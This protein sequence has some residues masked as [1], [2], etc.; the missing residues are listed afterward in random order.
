MRLGFQ[1]RVWHDR[2]AGCY[3]TN[4]Q[5]VNHTI[6]ASLTCRKVKY[7][8]H[9]SLC[10]WQIPFK[11]GHCKQIAWAYLDAQDAEQHSQIHNLG[12]I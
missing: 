7:A 12:H 8:R 3:S 4:L 2:L 5:K 10:V 6:H 1:F 11:I 9:A